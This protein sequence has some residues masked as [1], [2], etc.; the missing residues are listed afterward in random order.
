M[1]NAFAFIDQLRLMEPMRLPAFFVRPEQRV[2]PKVFKH[3]K[4]Q[5]NAKLFEFHHPD[6]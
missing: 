1:A 3:T 6:I 5:L 2:C 4:H